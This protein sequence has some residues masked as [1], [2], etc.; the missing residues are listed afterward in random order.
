MR[1]K[2]FRGIFYQVW[3]YSKQGGITPLQKSF[4]IV[5]LW[6]PSDDSAAL[7]W[8]VNILFSRERLTTTLVSKALVTV[9]IVALGIIVG[10]KA[11]TQRLD[12]AILGTTVLLVRT[13]RNLQVTNVGSVI[14]VLH[15]LLY[16]YHV[17]ME[18]TWII[19]WVRHVMAAPQAGI[20]S[21]VTWSTNVL[22]D[23]TAH[24]GR[25]SITN[26]V[27]A[28]PSITRLAWRKRDNVSSVPVESIVTKLAPLRR[29]ENVL[30]VIIASLD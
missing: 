25:D 18:L 3:V 10:P 26:L 30:L 21:M 29:Q 17:P 9:L 6:L 15:R 8:N 24:M 20:A 19:Q 14:I 27:P 1:N 12:P 22:R 2:H 11:S 7:Y 28:A 4:R 23:I 13:R 5:S 16:R